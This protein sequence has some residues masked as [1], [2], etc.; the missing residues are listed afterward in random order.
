MK[1][2]LQVIWATLLLVAIAA[3]CTATEEA[4]VKL[5]DAKQRISYTIGLDM[6]RSFASQEIDVDTAALLAGVRDGMGGQQPR[7]TDE[8]MQT[9]I[10]AFR[11]TMM[12]KQQAKL[13]ALAEKNRSQE[14]QG[15]RRRGP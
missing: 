4:A 1:K 2:T 9:E 5:E 12:A 3:G 10:K 8:E 11:E 14:R 6:G 7:L 13:R 15:A